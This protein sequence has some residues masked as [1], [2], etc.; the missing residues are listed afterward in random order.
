MWLVCC[1]RRTSATHEGGGVP[2]TPLLLRRI[3]LVV[4]WVVRLCGSRVQPVPG[5]CHSGVGRALHDPSL[6]HQRSFPCLLVPNGRAVSPLHCYSCDQ[7]GLVTTG[8]KGAPVGPG[9]FPLAAFTDPTGS[10]RSLCCGAWPWLRFSAASGWRGCTGSE[11]LPF[12]LPLPG[13]WR[14]GS[15]GFSSAAACT[16]AKKPG[17]GLCRAPGHP[18]ACRPVPSL[19]VFSHRSPMRSPGL[20]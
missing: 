4:T 15:C 10:S 16:H 11:R 12:Q 7:G 3:C 13:L 2:P 17:L 9:N 5:G 19:G 14:A 18:P 8:Q 1:G 6:R 20:R